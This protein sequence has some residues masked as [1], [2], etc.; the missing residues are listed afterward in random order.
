MQASAL[1]PLWWLYCSTSSRV[2]ALGDVSQR[3]DQLDETVALL[4]KA[5]GVP[6][7]EV[8]K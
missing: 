3:V 7:T 2:Q 5:A 6:E 1:L 4:C 8:K